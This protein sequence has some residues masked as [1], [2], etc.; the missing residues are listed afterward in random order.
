[1][2]Y[3]FNFKYRAIQCKKYKILNVKNIC[4]VFNINKSSIYRWKNEFYFKK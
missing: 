2:T 3:N 1:M 4:R